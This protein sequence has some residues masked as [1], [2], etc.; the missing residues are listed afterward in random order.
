MLANYKVVEQGNVEEL[1][2]LHHCPGQGDII[3]R[4]SRILA[5]VVM[6]ANHGRG[7]AL[8]R[9]A[10]HLGNPHLGGIYAALVDFV[11]AYYV[12]P[13]IEQDDPQV[14]LIPAFV[15]VWPF[16]G[17]GLDALTAPLGVGRGREGRSRSLAAAPGLHPWRLLAAQPA[18]G[19]RLP[20]RGRARAPRRPP[21][22]P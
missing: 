10:H 15:L 16:V 5:R 22:A 2:G 8:H 9:R 6:K 19:L 3:R 14:F 13:G 21:P 11:D 12:V 4:G 1:G 17:V 20:R 7:H 18:G